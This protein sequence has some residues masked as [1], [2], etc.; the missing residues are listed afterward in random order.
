[1]TAPNPQ[2]R[3]TNGHIAPSKETEPSN[4]TS[5][6]FL[7]RF[8]PILTSKTFTLD[9][10]PALPCQPRCGV[11]RSCGS[12]SICLHIV[13]VGNSHLNY[14]KKL[15]LLGRESSSE[16]RS[17]CCSCRGTQA[18]FNILSWTQWVPGIHMLHICTWRQNPPTYKISATFFVT[19]GY[20]KMCCREFSSRSLDTHMDS[21]LFKNVTRI[22]G[23][24]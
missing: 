22:A 24:R 1:M 9:L 21:L 20:W 3:L 5:Q 8:A 19:Q 10:C 6:T 2:K 14:F 11:F 13:V 7:R 4:L 15:G 16:V 18:Q 17:A 12:I 23:L